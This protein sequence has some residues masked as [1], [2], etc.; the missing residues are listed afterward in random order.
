MLGK[1]FMHNKNDS[2]EVFIK[3]LVAQCT[4]SCILRGN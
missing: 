3:R 1:F 4:D 2:E